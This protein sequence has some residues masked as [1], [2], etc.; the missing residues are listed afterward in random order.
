MA[1]CPRLTELS[2]ISP[3]PYDYFG[4]SDWDVL[5]EWARMVR[6][7]MSDSIVACKAHQDFN[8]LQIVRLPMEPP[9][10]DCRCDEP[11]ECGSIP[12]TSWERMLAKHV[13]GLGEWAM[14]CLEKARTGCLKGEGRKRITVRTV[15]F[16]YDYPVKVKEYEVGSTS[17]RM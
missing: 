2:V 11:C 13:K 5:L 3:Y 4:W 16:S 10:R 14:E 6:P 1:A 9:P 17:S 8:T 15:E 12:M 7:A